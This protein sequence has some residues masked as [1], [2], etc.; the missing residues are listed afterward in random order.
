MEDNHEA[1]IKD[2]VEAVKMKRP[3]V[4]ILGAGA[5]RA[6]CINGDKNN[7]A[8]PLMSDLV[9]VL[10][11]GQTLKDW[12]FDPKGNF[13][14]LFSS[15]HEK[16]EHEKIRSVEVIVENY[17]K[18]LKLPDR[19]NLYDHLVLSLREKDLIATFNWDPLLLEAYLRNKNSGLKLPRLVFL[20]GNVSIGICSANKHVGVLN[21]ICSCKRLLTKVP[22]LYPIG[23]KNY[24]DSLFIANEWNVLKR[25][26]KSAFMITIFGYSGPKSDQEAIALMSE[27]WGPG[28]ERSMEQ[29]S[30]IS[31]QS[32][33]E[34]TEN[35]DKFIHSHHYEIQKDFYD[36]WL[37]NHPRRTGEAYLHQYLEAKFIDNNPIP[38]DLDFPELWKWYDQFKPAESSMSN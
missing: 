37:A 18:S 29:T 34:I 3:H 12:G 17:F 5:S 2:E 15:L 7:R 20:H 30:F 23:K 16:G 25:Y 31:L 36:S 6:A 22:L 13:E 26:L 32:E 10:G 21:G 14:D 9:E 19:P 11:L 35:W 27:A 1:S 33:G 28:S 38:K 24:S 4:F 8:L